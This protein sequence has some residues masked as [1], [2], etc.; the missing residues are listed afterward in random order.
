MSKYVIFVCLFVLCALTPPACGL[1]LSSINLC[2]VL[3]CSH[4][5]SQ[6]YDPHSAF[7]LIVQAPCGSPY[8]FLMGLQNPYGAGM[9]SFDFLAYRCSN[10]C[11]ASPI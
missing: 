9:D 3:F 11:M 1:S 5:G 4:T 8:G 10:T 7:K 6:V 2:S